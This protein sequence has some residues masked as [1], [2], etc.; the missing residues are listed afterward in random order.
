MK[1]PTRPTLLVIS[2]ILALAAFT[3]SADLISPSP[4]CSKPNRPYRFD[5]QWQIDSFRADV[6]RYRDCIESFV[7]DQNSAAER[8]QRAAQNA[9]DEWNRFVQT[10]LN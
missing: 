1:A 5:N 10:E 4:Y 9:I 8:H 3:A 2:A 6:D 7:D